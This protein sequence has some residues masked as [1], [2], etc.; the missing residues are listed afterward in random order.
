MNKTKKTNTVLSESGS[1]KQ[2][3]DGQLS[4][5]MQKSNK[6]TKPTP[7]ATPKFG[8]LGK[9]LGSKFSKRGDNVWRPTK[10]GG[11]NRQ[12]KP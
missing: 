2:N 7:K 11:R 4:S 10:P 3:P 6:K 12:G 1:D 5:D 9:D 8:I